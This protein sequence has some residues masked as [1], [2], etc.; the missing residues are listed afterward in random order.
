VSRS[1]TIAKHPVHEPS[2]DYAWLREQGI[3]HVESLGSALWTDYNLHDP[4]ITLL[5]LLC[6]AITDLAHRADFPIPDL[7]AEPPTV[8][9]DPTRQAFY[10]AREVLTVN[11][12]GIRDYRKK[13][14]DLE[15]VKNAWLTVLEQYD[16]TIFADCA[17]SELRYQPET[18]HRV[19][20][21]GL[22]DVKVEFEDDE[23]MGNLNSGKVYYRF[24]Y[25]TGIANRTT[26][27][28]ELR[29]PS[30]NA[31]EADAATYAGFRSPSGAISGQVTAQ[32]ISGN[33]ADDKDV[34]SADQANALKTVL[35]V[36][37]S[38]DYL[39]DASDLN[40]TASI[41]FADVPLRVWFH[42]DA[43]RRA[44][45]WNDLKAALSDATP[46]GVIGRYHAAL[47]KA[48]AI[49]AA[50]RSCLLA[51]RNLCE[52]WRHV[53]SVPVEDV[54]V[55]ADIDVEPSADIE[56]VLAEAYD[57]IVQYLSPDLRFYSLA[58]LLEAKT[59]V[60]DIFDGPKL[61]RGFLDDAEVDATQLRTRL[62]AS[63]IIN[64]LV[65]IDG[66]KAVRNFRFSRYDDEGRQIGA[67]QPWELEVTPGRGPR[68]YAL[69]SKFLVFKNGL[70]FL[71]DAA[72][73]RDI[74][75][76]IRGKRLRP[77][78]SKAAS[79]LEVPRGT[80]LPL[81]DFT[82]AQY[83]LPRTYGVGPEGLP[84]SVGEPRLAQAK[85]LRAYLLFFEQ[86]LVNYLAQ[87]AHVKDLFAVDDTV[88]RSMFTR[89]IDDSLL[90]GVEAELYRGMDDNKLQSI[91]ESQ[92]TWLDRRNRF[93]DHV[94][95]R[96]AE[97]FAD[98]SVM[99]YRHAGS[100]T[101]AQSQLIENK[102]AFLRDLPAMTH[103]RAKAFDYAVPAAFCPLAPPHA[104]GNAPGLSL[105][106]K[107][108]LGL[109]APDDR[110]LVIEHLLLRP[111]AIDDPLLSVC[112]PEDC[113]T[114]GE[115]D[116]YSFRITVVLAGEGGVENSDIDWRRFAENA[117]R[118]EVPAHLAV[119]VCWVS[120]GQ[121]DEIEA[122]WCAWLVRV[123]AEPP[124]AGDQKM[125]LIEL[126]TVFHA[127]KSVYPPATLHDC[128]DGNDENRV[129]LDR[130]VITS[131]E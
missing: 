37:L 67:T 1:L 69:A 45:D 111:R 2:R 99:L 80:Y 115:E 8:V 89:L 35:Y 83:Q 82:P 30:W 27:L 131:K 66:V 122:A 127:L 88:D 4:G 12:L 71:P 53:T 91:V 124:Q 63:D 118:Y 60:E 40:S 117:I 112:L 29:L 15:G 84:A 123:R 39:T 56:A 3:K 103:D 54:A 98:Y 7:I 57:L 92:S 42:S 130:T 128:G 95:S 19:H 38:A 43:D 36:T 52:D 96:F 116:P 105:R 26:A 25:T 72:E 73:L 47:L 113:S 78:L 17:S 49:L 46:A 79:D 62:Y 23:E 106:I 102:I 50:A 81:E 109:K 14:I 22:Y 41:T 65:D 10:T 74:L 13:L 55:C 61:S 44:L 9:P 5:E 18:E 76:V 120:S 121:L 114:C 48:D 93:L 108:L 97:S 31:L 59:P 90:P 20:P 16:I 68:F 21:R 110:V 129:Y 126:L 87:L 70:P 119:K 58:E 6:Y 125:A 28:V 24:G 33:R 51:T 11:P 86:L 107:R 64:L 101:A 100:K 34:D 77:K 85:Q 75:Q 32:W 104:Q 94:L